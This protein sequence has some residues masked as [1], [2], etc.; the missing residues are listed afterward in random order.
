MKI[1]L[2]DVRGPDSVRATSLVPGKKFREWMNPHSYRCLPLVAA[3]TFGW[4]V[5]TEKD[6][7]VDWNGGPALLD[8]DVVEGF[9][10]AESHFGLGTITLEVG[11]TWKT[12]PGIHIM[13]MPVPN[14]DF[15][16]MQALTAI[17]ESDVLKY[18]WFMTLR[19]TR[20][21]VIRIPAGTPIARVVPVRLGD[22]VGA[23]L[24]VEEEP[25]EYTEA[26]RY[27]AELRRTSGKSWNRIYHE[28]AN[29][30]V[31]RTPE[32]GVAP[33]DILADNGILAVPEFLTKE[34]CATLLDYVSRTEPDRSDPGSP[35]DQRTFAFG[36]ED[37]GEELYE[38]I[39]KGAEKV[40]ND[41]YG[42]KMELSETHMVRWRT[43]DYMR[44][45][46]DLAGGIFKFRHYAS[47]IYLNDDY[48]G[49][50][51][52]IPTL[53]LEIAPMAGAL[54]AMNGSEVFHGVKEIKSGERITCI[55]WL[56]DPDRQS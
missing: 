14:T 44:P 38:K 55:A 37:V 16:D 22:V 47:I 2:F 31:V 23:S 25:E 27:H 49:G 19:C 9:D 6:I 53:D 41:W 43:G 26:R 51:L 35:W 20:T 10:I 18:P 33:S 48:T 5:V 50:E 1:E 42:K 39:T 54:V 11:Y 3:N 46:S 15:L 45:H 32:L 30:R 13:V 34:E 7:V 40:I 12:E 8:L 17:M 36:P 21:G 4:D 29:H 28:T 52:Y 24:T 56:R